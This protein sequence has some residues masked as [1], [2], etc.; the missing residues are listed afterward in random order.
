MAELFDLIKKLQKPE[1]GLKRIGLRLVAYARDAFQKQE[2]AVGAWPERYPQDSPPKLNYAGA[3]ND[4]NAGGR[5]KARRYA[6]RP[7]A[8]DTGALRRSITS[9][10][11][12]RVVRV[13]SPLQYAGVQNAGG[14]TRISIHPRVIPKLRRLQARKPDPVI[15]KFLKKLQGDGLELRTKVNPRPFV[16]L[17]PVR[18]RHVV[19]ILVEWLH[20]R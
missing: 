20:G 4:L 13:G 14:Y 6:D 19:D 7:A 3:L 12:N 10:V 9:E 18:L 11:S 5:I 15:E 1:V 8:I 17:T 16:G 2:S